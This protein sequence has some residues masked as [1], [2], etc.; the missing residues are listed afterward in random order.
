MT[1]FIDRR[2]FNSALGSFALAGMLGTSAEAQQGSDFYKGKQ[3]NLDRR[4]GTGGG[5]DLCASRRPHMSASSTGN[6]NVVVQNMPG[7]GSCAP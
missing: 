6:P 4:Y 2:R 5:F 3:I 1:N 7:A